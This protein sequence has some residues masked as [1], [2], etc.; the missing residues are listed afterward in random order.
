MGS[1]ASSFIVDNVIIGLAQPLTE[2]HGNNDD[3]DIL[4]NVDFLMTAFS[5]PDDLTNVA[6][7]SASAESSDVGSGCIHVF[8]PLA[9]GAAIW[10]APVLRDCG[11]NAPQQG[12][13]GIRGVSAVV[14][15]DTDEARRAT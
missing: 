11:P 8:L 6:T 10:R 9:L 2:T 4:C 14:T 7:R 5:G 13:T 1:A 3:R 15:D 12:G